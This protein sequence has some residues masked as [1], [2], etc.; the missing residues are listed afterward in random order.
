[1]RVRLYILLFTMFLSSV[2]L[3]CGSTT[4]A[5]ISFE[6][7][8]HDFGSINIEESAQIDIIV[9]NKRKDSVTLTRITI[10]NF[11]FYIIKGG[12]P[13]T[14]VP[15]RTD[16]IITVQYSPRLPGGI[17]NGIL[18]IEYNFGLK[19]LIMEIPLTGTAIPVPKINVN[20]TAYDWQDLLIRTTKTKDFVIRNIGTA[21]LNVYSLIISGTDASLFTITAGSTGATIDPQNFFTITVEFAPLSVGNKSAILEF[22][23]NAINLA[24][25]ISINLEGHCFDIPI[26]EIDPPSVFDFQK[27]AKGDSKTETFTISNLGGE[28]LVMNSILNATA[29]TVTAGKAPFT[30]VPGD[31]HNIEITFA[32]TTL[33]ITNKSLTFVHNAPTNP[34]TLQVKGEAFRGLPYVED[35]E[36]T[37]KGQIPSGWTISRDTGSNTSGTQWNWQVDDGT[38]KNTNNTGG[39]GKFATADSDRF[40]SALYKDYLTS[41]VIDCSTYTTGTVSLEFDG[42]LQVITP[43]EIG[44]VEIYDG[45]DWQI[46]ED[47]NSDWTITGEHKSYDITQYAL[48]NADMKIRFYY[49]NPLQF[50]YYFQVDNIEV[51]RN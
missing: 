49:E 22:Q 14:Y 44:R 50:M 39:S 3:S 46:L 30:V 10:N 15:G 1:M 19:P 5:S 51:T 42:N 47:W 35:F 40:L 21:S 43:N 23:H 12:T 41:P 13:S 37:A 32:P 16:H 26:F 24:S 36:S 8:T 25:P 9:S 29:F 4:S 18:K 20:P 7:T 17:K 6:P 34:D 31:T 48:G 28:D 33:G 45:A 2:L 11:E 38:S 27:I